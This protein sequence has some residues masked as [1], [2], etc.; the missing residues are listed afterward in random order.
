VERGRFQRFAEVR[1][2]FL[3]LIRAHQLLR[4]AFLIFTTVGGR[5]RNIR[6]IIVGENYPDNALIILISPYLR[7][8]EVFIRSDMP[9]SWHPLHNPFFLT[10]ASQ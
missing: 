5:L 7:R 1:Q 4:R 8:K 3:R 2:A 9:K 10:L 6:V